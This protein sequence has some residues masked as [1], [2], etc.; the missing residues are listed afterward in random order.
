MDFSEFDEKYLQR[1]NPQQRE[2]VLA[3]DGPVLLL[4]TPGSG[5]TTVLVHRLGYMLLCRGISPRAVLT[6]TYTRSAARDMK[7]RFASLLSLPLRCP[8]APS[9][10]FRPV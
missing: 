10:A 2:A 4:A 3:V 6:M 8:S 9:T 7:L 5:K 1:L